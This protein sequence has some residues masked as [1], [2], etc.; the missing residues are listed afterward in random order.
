M[1]LMATILACSL[2]RDEGLVRAIAES[3]SRGNPYAVLVPPQ[4]DFGKWNNHRERKLEDSNADGNPE[5]RTSFR[6]KDRA[7]GRDLIGVGLVG[8][9]WCQR[10]P[11]PSGE[12]L[13]SLLANPEG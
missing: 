12:R 9:S 8:A 11:A 7:H 6:R 13:R 10:L 2:Y 3:N 4:L 5:G 1:D